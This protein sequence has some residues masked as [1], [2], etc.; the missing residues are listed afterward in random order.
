[1]KKMFLATALLLITSGSVQAT[2]I[3]RACLSANRDGTNR[4]MCGCIQDVANLTLTNKDQKLAS[5]FFKD[6]QK[7]Q[8]I[9]QSNRSSHSK[10]WNR[11]KAFGATAEA[12]CSQT[13]D[14]SR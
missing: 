14:I 5:S 4:A 9:R 8:D 2:V 11:Y 12:F 13:S 6:P 7:A 10:F 1:M 3:E